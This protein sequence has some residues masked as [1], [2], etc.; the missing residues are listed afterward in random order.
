MRVDTETQVARKYLGGGLYKLNPVDPQ[1][2]NRLVSTLE[3]ETWISWFQSLL[4]QMQLVPLQLGKGQPKFVVCRALNYKC[5]KQKNMNKKGNP[6]EVIPGVKVPDKFTSRFSRMFDSSN[7]DPRRG[8]Q[9]G[10][11]MGGAGMH[12]YNKKRTSESVADMHD[13]DPVDVHTGFK[14]PHGGAVQVE[15]SLSIA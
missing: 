4:F 2:E 7:K 15:F 3:P 11:L 5:L 12:V 6:C 13:R 9:V 10:R 14:Y 8:P 1:L